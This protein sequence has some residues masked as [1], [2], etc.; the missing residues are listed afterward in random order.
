MKPNEVPL[1]AAPPLALNGRVLRMEADSRSHAAASSFHSI[2]AN[3]INQLGDRLPKFDVKSECNTALKSLRFPSYRP[4][5]RCAQW[6]RHCR[7][8]AEAPVKGK[9]P[10]LK[11]LGH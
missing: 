9:A 1:D 2:T 8:E 6:S 11:L 5:I 7:R 3:H 4:Q 10:T